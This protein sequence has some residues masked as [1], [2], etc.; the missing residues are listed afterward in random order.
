ME[1][2]VFVVEAIQVVCDQPIVPG[3]SFA[4]DPRRRAASTGSPPS[5][6]SMSFQTPPSSPKQ[7]LLGHWH[8]EESDGNRWLGCSR[9]SS[10]E[11]HA[12]KR[13]G[14]PKQRVGSIPEKARTSTWKREGLVS[15]PLSVIG[16]VD[17]PPDVIEE[18]QWPSFIQKNPRPFARRTS[19][20]FRILASRRRQQLG[21][22]SYCALHP[23]TVIVNHINIR[24]LLEE[25]NSK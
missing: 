22:R 7:R 17:F 10:G 6:S 11:P 20:D 1:G 25:T 21:T 23:S 8:G 15:I 19:V 14:S 5:I 3:S 9:D 4:I 16:S 13:P 2:V 24:G 18:Y 12:K